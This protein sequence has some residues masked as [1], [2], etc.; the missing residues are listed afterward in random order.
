MRQR[1]EL[2]RAMA[3]C[4]ELLL[5]DEAW[6]GVD[7]KHRHGVFGAVDK[8]LKRIRACVLATTHADIDVLRVGDRVYSVAGA[9]ISEVF[10]A[11]GLRRE[12][13]RGMDAGDLLQAPE[14]KEMVNALGG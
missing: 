8:F 6:S 11:A 3:F 5:L 9:R 14:M 1:V 4:P 2:A 10:A 13:R 12:G 7:G